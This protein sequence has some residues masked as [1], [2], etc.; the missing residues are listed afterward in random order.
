M[1]ADAPASAGLRSAPKTVLKYYV[2][3]TDR[4][5]LSNRETLNGLL[6]SPAVSLGVGRHGFLENGFAA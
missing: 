2:H 1:R 5:S 3:A 4:L 6:R